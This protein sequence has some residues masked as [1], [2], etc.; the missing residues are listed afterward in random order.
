M[1]WVDALVAT[2]FKYKLTHLLLCIQI[3]SD[4]L[5]NYSCKLFWSTLLQIQEKLPFEE[6][7][8]TFLRDLGY[9]GEIKMINDVKC[10][11]L[12]QLG[13]NLP[14]VINT[15]LSGKNIR[16]LR[17]LQRV[18]CPLLG[19][20]P[21][22]KNESKVSKRALDLT[23]NDSPKRQMTQDLEKLLQ[24]ARRWQ[25]GYMQR[26]SMDKGL[27]VLSEVW[28]YRKLNKLNAGHWK[29]ARHISHLSRQPAQC[30]M[31]GNW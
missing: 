14:A 13:V 31:E 27:K 17:I 11:K 16:K 25:T 6:V 7:I 30:A 24:P 5:G 20:E 9:S 22:Q 4:V 1:H 21:S 23:E 10:H 26:P 19:A 12:H 8:L 28:L 29:E 18:L 2:A 3:L 15:C